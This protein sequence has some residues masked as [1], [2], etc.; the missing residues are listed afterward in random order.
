[1][2]IRAWAATGAALSLA[3]C[4][5]AGAV[6][7]GLLSG[8]EGL[9][10][11]EDAVRASILQRRDDGLAAGIEHLFIQPAVLA[12]GVGEEL[13]EAERTL[14]LRE[15]DRQICYELSERFTVLAEAAPDAARVRAV[16]SRITPT[17][18]VGS[19]ASAASGFFIPGPPMPRAGSRRPTVRRSTCRPSNSQPG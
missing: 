12:P 13:T 2:N 14:V 5:A 16:V 3:G 19:A 17:G 11:R 7:S 8:Y 4:G 18:R 6:P 9:T 15:V 1:M 10:A